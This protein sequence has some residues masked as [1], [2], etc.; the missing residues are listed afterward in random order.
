MER[1]LSEK[2]GKRLFWRSHTCLG[3]T[4][5]ELLVVIAIIGILVALLLPAVQ[6]A[7]EAARRMQCA[8]NLKQLGLGLI[9][10]E[11]AKKAFPPGAF[12]TDLKWQ[13]FPSHFTNWA[14]EVLPFIEEQPL[15]DQYDQTLFNTHPDNLPVL[16]TR[17]GVMECPS[18]PLEQGLRV[19]DKIEHA[20]A[21][22]P[23]SYKG[24]SG[25]RWGSTNGFYDF[26]GFANNPARVREK[27]GPLYFVGL[28]ELD[29]VKF[30]DI[31][32]GTSKSLLVGEYSTHEETV[33][34]SAIGSGSWASTHAYHNLAATQPESYTRT[35]DFDRCII[36]NGNQWWQCDRAF[37][38]FH[39]GVIQF[40]QCDGSVLALSDDI[41]GLVF[42]GMGTIS[43]D[44][45]LLN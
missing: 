32:D 29:P 8:N 27:R 12:G 40:V 31:T 18:G 2:T 45:D 20:G 44:D 23:G 19:V 30:S 38:S 5:V 35:P 36:S 3:F 34:T 9:T 42:S 41:D 43:G 4:L 37:A 11:S 22:A 25:T 39:A 6:S 17:L 1:E 14:I 24:V 21:I 15:Y 16:Q 33:D 10:H 13:R 28:G 26:P 7:R